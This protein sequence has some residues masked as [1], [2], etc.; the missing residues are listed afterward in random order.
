MAAISINP[1]KFKIQFVANTDTRIH[2]GLPVIE[3][4]ARRFG[5]WKKIRA[6]RCLDPRRDRSRGYSP[7]VIVG[8]L[9]YALCSGGGCLSES[10]ALNDDP[11]VRELFGVAKIRRPVPS[12]RGV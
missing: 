7:E 10:E 11:L 6:L 9:I 5:L 12:R 8:Q 3:A 4:M 2:A 1:K